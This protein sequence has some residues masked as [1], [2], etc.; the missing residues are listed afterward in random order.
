MAQ[1]PRNKVS[2][3]SY[4]YVWVLARPLGRS[5]MLAIHPPFKYAWMTRT[6]SPARCA[7][8]RWNLFGLLLFSNARK[9]RAPRKHQSATTMQ[10]A[11]LR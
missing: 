1:R 11:D 8:G 5:A 7:L 2:P 10:G 6:R 4:Y 3:R 9:E